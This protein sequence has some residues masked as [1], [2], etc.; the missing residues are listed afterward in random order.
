MTRFW[1]MIIEGLRT[2]TLFP[3]LVRHTEYTLNDRTVTLDSSDD[4]REAMAAALEAF[5]ENWEAL[6]RDVEQICPGWS[7]TPTWGA[8]H[9]ASLREEAA[10]L[11]KGKQ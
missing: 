5:A 8:N 9:A 11:R 4:E 10:E 6:E 2:L 1:N 7:S 3:A